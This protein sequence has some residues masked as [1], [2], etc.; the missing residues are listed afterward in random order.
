[1]VNKEVGG[2]R[3]K[4][5]AR[6]FVRMQVAAVKCHIP[7]HGYFADADKSDVRGLGV[8]RHVNFIGNGASK[9][10]QHALCRDHVALTQIAK[11]QRR[12]TTFNFGRRRHEQRDFRRPIFGDPQVQ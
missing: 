2:Q 6:R 10:I 11:S 1:M 3:G 5:C 9:F 12:R 8:V 7:A 4:R